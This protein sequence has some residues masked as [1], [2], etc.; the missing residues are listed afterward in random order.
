MKSSGQPALVTSRGVSI[1]VA[2]AIIIVALIKADKKDI[3]EIVRLL[4]SSDAWAVTG[5]IV[6]VVILLSAIV[7]IK[8]LCRVYDKEIDRIA[9]E[10]DTLQSVLI[11]SSK[12]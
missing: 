4:T 9:K 8:M 7:I 2:G 1:L 6:A 11:E 5:W 12:Q 10:R 3:P